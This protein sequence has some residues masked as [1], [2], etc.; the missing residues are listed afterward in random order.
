MN[1]VPFDGRCGINDY[2]D[3]VNKKSVY[4][5]HMEHVVPFENI[6]DIKVLMDYLFIIIEKY[7]IYIEIEYQANMG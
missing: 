2:K 3:L 7:L 4:N 5:G 1:L 6:K